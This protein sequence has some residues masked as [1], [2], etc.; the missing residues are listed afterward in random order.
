M[1][2]IMRSSIRHGGIVKCDAPKCAARFTSYSMLSIIR[3]QAR[4]V[5]WMRVPAWQVIGAEHP[6]PH[7]VCP[8]HVKDAVDA[9]ANRTQVLKAARDKAKAERQAE[10]DEK[11]AK[12]KAAKKAA[13]AAVK[14]ADKKKKKKKAKAEAKLEATA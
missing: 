6:N 8:L 5:G 11:K 4:G 12:Q 2:K 1:Q 10:R 14:K 13:A 9:K 7:D 3:L